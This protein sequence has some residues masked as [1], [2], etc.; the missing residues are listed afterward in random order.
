MARSIRCPVMALSDTQLS[1]NEASVAGGAVFAGYL[2]AVLFSCTDTS[3]DVF[4]LRLYKEK[5][6]KSLSQVQSDKDICPGWKGNRGGV[7]GPIVATYAATAEMM[8]E[9]VNESICV[10]GGKNCL[11][12][13]YRVGTDLPNT[14]VELLDGLKQRPAKHY[15]AVNAN[16][17]SPFG[18]FLLVPVV[19][20]MEKGACTF[21][22]V[23][24]FVPPGVYELV[25]EFGETAIESIGITVRVHDC[26]VDESVSSAGFCE[27]CSSTTY[28][29]RLS[30]KACN[31]CPENG[32]C[33]SKTIT[34]DDGYW[35]MTPCSVHLRRCLPTSA[36]EFEGRSKNLTNMVRD[37]SSCDF[38][39]EWI[40]AY[41]KAQCAEVGY[42]FLSLDISIISSSVSKGSRR[43]ALWILRRRLRIRSFLKMQKVFE[44][45]L[46]RG[47]HSG[48]GDLSLDIDGHHD[49][50]H[51]QHSPER[52]RA[53]SLSEHT[54]FVGGSDRISTFATG[55]ECRRRSSSHH[56]VNAL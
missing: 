48:V 36:C 8:L 11:I 32:N 6:W 10:S 22:S 18:Q 9:D 53:N 34:P 56:R 13:G 19:I 35:Q 49:P 5:E 2:K 40:E 17:S 26:S 54:V 55:S 43:T 27:S 7:Y 45:V 4:G 42:I 52:H 25:V 12:E 1:D 23:K 37:V 38:D 24:G 39:A 30:A 31:P 21:R 46:Q 14:T 15:H 41:T 44:G 16:M 51:G 28:N 20:P 47:L 29:F 3:S 33:E 50:R